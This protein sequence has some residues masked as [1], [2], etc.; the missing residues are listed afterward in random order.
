MDAKPLLN[1]FEPLF[2]WL[3]EQNGNSVGWN[4]G[5]SV[6]SRS[7]NSVGWFSDWSPCEFTELT[8][9]KSLPLCF[10]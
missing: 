7:G 10:P 9:F 1:Y 5:N 2:T 3:K 4:S 8:H 6:E